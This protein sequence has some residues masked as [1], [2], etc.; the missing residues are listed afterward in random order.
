MLNK[1]T[2]IS[3][4]LKPYRLV[5]G[6]TTGIQYDRKDYKTQ[7]RNDFKA[8]EPDFRLPVVLDSEQIDRQN[9]SQCHRHPHSSI[10][11][12]RPERD[13]HGGRGDLG[14]EDKNPA[15]IVVEAHGA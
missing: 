2:G 13:E 9:D 3:P 11:R 14:S 5:V 12:C 15:E 1:R 4:E 8:C 6:S 10:D 7:H